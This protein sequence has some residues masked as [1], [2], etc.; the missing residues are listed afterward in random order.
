MK[1]PFKPAPLPNHILNLQGMIRRLNSDILRQAANADKAR[2]LF[3]AGRFTR[4]QAD[5]CIATSAQAATKAEAAASRLR[6]ELDALQTALA[7]EEREALARRAVAAPRFAWA[8]GMQYLAEGRAYRLADDDFFGAI[9]LPPDHLPNLGDARTLDALRYLA[10]ASAEASPAEIV[11]A[12]EG[13][14]P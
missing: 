11:A 8:S 1:S 6:A 4:E 12:L 5:F 3:A 14:A 10:G 9:V 13:G 2:E 7:A